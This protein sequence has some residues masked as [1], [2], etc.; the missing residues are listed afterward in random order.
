LPTGTYRI[1]PATG[2]DLVNE[3]AYL[4]KIALLSGG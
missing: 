4:V 3:D 1:V 2:G